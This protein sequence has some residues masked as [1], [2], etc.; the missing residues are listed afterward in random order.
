MTKICI[1]ISP[2][3]MKSQFKSIWKNLNI[4]ALQKLKLSMI[5]KQWIKFS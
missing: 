3:L 1:N 4:L 5:M 2:F